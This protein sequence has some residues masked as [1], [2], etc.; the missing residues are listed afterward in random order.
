MRTLL[1]D[2]DEWAYKAA[3][4]GQ[5]R[6]YLAMEGD[7]EVFRGKRRKDVIEHI[8]DH[9]W[10][11]IDEVE[12]LGDAPVLAR[13][14][15]WIGA[16]RNHVEFATGEQTDVKVFLTGR[17]NFRYKTAS[18]LPYKGNR[19]HD[20]RPIYLEFIR[21]YLKSDWYA[22]TIDYLEADDMMAANQRE[23]SIIVT[24]DKDL[25]MVPGTRYSTSLN[26]LLELKE[27][28][29]SKFFYCQ[30][31]T[32][33]STDNIPGLSFVGEKGAASMLSG[34]STPLEM[35]RKVLEIYTHLMIDGKHFVAKGKK[36]GEILWET[37]KS[38]KEAI[39]EIGNLL[40]MRRSLVEDAYWNP[41]D[42]QE[43][44]LPKESEEVPLVTVEGQ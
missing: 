30:I 36:K 1:I 12:D 3:H 40:W 35:Y 7:R 20:K 2:G 31:L 39:W 26:K 41:P 44:E 6:W 22:S 15:E 37:S 42:E 28:Y 13:A 29:C 4:S 21:N 25:N 32:G 16:I 10:E 38:P 24:Q 8:G 23:G 27:P 5:Q 11:L 19:D 43:S 17:H 34:L 18:I 9:D 33:D 14:Q